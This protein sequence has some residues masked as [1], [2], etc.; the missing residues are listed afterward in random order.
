MNMIRNIQIADLNA[1]NACFA[2]MAWKKLR[3]FYFDL[4]KERFSSLSV[5]NSLHVKGDI[6]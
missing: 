4:G 6:A 1:F 5:A 3:G 2:V